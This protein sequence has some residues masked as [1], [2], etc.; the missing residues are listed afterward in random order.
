MVKAT[1][2]RLNA[3][4]KTTSSSTSVQSDD[5]S[6]TDA[7][8]DVVLAGD[9]FYDRDHERPRSALVFR[10]WQNAARLVLVGDPG[11][12]YCPNDQNGASR[13]LPWFR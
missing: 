13:H 10:G 5:R 4:T 3:L 7:G 11:R 9:V 8:W 6:G 2:A 12:S 1:A